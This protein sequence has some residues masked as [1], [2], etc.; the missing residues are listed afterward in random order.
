V[1]GPL[2]AGAGLIALFARHA[3][4]AADPLL[5]VR[6]L[7]VPSVAASCATLFLLGAAYLGALFLLPLFFQSARGESPFDAGLL[8]APQGVA[9]ALAITLAG[10]ATDRVGPDRVVLA[11]LVPFALA[12]AGLTHVTATTPTLVLEALLCLFGL[13]MGATM[14]PAT[15]AAFRPLAR[16]QVAQAT[17]LVTIVQRVGSSLGVALVAVVLGGAQTKSAAE[18]GDAFSWLC[19][20]ALCAFAPAA[21]LG[22]R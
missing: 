16:A 19:A 13:G 21:L 14:M 11:G 4:R 20:L 3:L 22:R 17:A 12:L 8:L 9:A 6:L 10:R 15:T 5:D 1:L 2:V 18:L 7:R